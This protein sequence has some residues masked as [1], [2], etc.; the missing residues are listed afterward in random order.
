MVQVKNSIMATIAAIITNT[1]RFIPF[2]PDSAPA[3]GGVSF[4]SDDVFFD[5][6]FAPQRGFHQLFLG[7]MLINQIGF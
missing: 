5:M 7:Q 6:A 4:I 3:A 2:S 1:W